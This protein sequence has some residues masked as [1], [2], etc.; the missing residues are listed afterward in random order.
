[1][2]KFDFE[3]QTMLLF[4]SVFLMVIELLVVN[5][6]ILMLKPLN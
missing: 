2:N 3:V 6:R 1:M 5:F 4:L